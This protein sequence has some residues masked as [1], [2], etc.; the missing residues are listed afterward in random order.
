MLRRISLLICLA[1]ALLTAQ[2]AG[3]QAPGH[4]AFGLGVGTDGAGAEL[5]IRLDPH[6][7]L[8]A[9]YAST[10]GLVKFS[11]GDIAVPE[12]PGN[13]HG[14]SVQVPLNIQSPMGDGRLLLDF[15]PGESTFH[16]TVGTYLGP[17]TLLKGSFS[18]LPSDYNTVGID[19]DGYLV[20]ASGGYLE[21]TFRASGLGITGGAF[22]V[23]P[24]VGLGFGR[25]VQ[26]KKK[27]TFTF[28]FGVQY[29]G[30]PALYALGE[31]ITGRKKQ[32]ALPGDLISQVAGITLV[33]YTRWMV[34]WP[35]L[36][37]HLYFR[38]F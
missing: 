38:L 30:Q 26:Q 37:V 19:V 9:G 23:K 25:A 17:S 15:F 29:Q 14:S 31:G 21:A 8:R 2:P 3:A 32:V 36:N 6:T 20:R 33:D 34:F 16:I 1:A 12:H 24:Y 13:P 27:V 35:T 11:A 5:A 10:Y 28:D 4:V 22:A 7:Q 18:N